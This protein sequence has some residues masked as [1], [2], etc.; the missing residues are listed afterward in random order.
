MVSEEDGVERS[1]LDSVA[2][3]DPA[4]VEDRTGRETDAATK[5]QLDAN[6]RMRQ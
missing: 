3:P 1:A 5:Q 2:R 6:G 4:E